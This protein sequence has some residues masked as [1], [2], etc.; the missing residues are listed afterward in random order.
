LLLKKKLLTIKDQNK[1]GI[2][3]FDEI[4]LRASIEG[5]NNCLN[6]TRLQDYGQDA[7]I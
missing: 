5:N 6:Y 7:D 3:V 2:L 4:F 1:Y